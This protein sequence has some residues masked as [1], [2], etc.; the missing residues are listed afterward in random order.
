MTHFHGA[1]LTAAENVALLFMEARPGSGINFATGNAGLSARI[2]EMIVGA[3]IESM[4][5]SII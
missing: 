1:L 5:G 2:V 3:P 4:F